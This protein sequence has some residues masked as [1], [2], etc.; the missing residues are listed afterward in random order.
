MK[1]RDLVVADAVIPSL[2]ATEKE[3]AIREIVVRLVEAGRIDE[4]DRVGIVRSLL[5]REKLGSTGI[6]G[7]VALPHAKHAKV[8]ETLCAIARSEQG[9]EFNALDGE[10]VHLVFLVAS[11]AQGEQIG[12]VKVLE[13]ISM[14]LRHQDFSRFLLAA[15]TDQAMLEVV[16]E[17]DSLWGDE[18]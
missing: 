15:K 18:A 8:A 7:G 11:P 5:N 9:I 4:A 2:A 13:R 16:E 1:L 14:M 10:P 12:R 3:D 17:A 6:G